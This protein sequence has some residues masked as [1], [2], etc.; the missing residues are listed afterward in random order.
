MIYTAAVGT[1]CKINA[2]LFS[3][4]CTTD[5]LQGFQGHPDGWT[6]FLSDPNKLLRSFKCYRE[7]AHVDI[8]VIFTPHS[9]HIEYRDQNERSMAGLTNGLWLPSTRREL[10]FGQPTDRYSSTSQLLCDQTCR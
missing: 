2:I 8:P 3:T 7:M 6:F 4:L 9:G 1:V 5:N 10:R